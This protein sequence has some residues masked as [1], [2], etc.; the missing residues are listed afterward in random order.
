MLS[1]NTYRES[2]IGCLMTS[3]YL[4]LSGLEVS[5]ILSSRDLYIVGS[6][7]SC[8][9]AGLPVPQRSFYRTI[10]CVMLYNIVLAGGGLFSC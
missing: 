6:I 7:L 2:Y 10:K 4:T 9:R 8:G 1:L 3:L 5:Y